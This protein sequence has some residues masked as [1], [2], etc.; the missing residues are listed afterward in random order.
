MKASKTGK[1]F[2]ICILCINHRAWH[3]TELRTDI[4]NEWRMMSILDLLLGNRNH[5]TVSWESK[6]E[7]SKQHLVIKSERCVCSEGKAYGEFRGRQSD[8]EVIHKLTFSYNSLLQKFGDDQF[9]F[10][11]QIIP[12]KH[13]WIN[14]SNLLLAK[15]RS[16]AFCLIHFSYLVLRGLSSWKISFYIPYNPLFSMNKNFLQNGKWGFGFIPNFWF[17][18]YNLVLSCK[19]VKHSRQN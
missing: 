11:E 8:A 10:S 9:F 2:S 4:L 13:S 16:N 7:K 19:G 14:H 3:G 18:L 15:R 5:Q 12:F 17:T 1:Y 6:H